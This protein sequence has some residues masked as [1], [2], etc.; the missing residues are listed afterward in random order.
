MI[1]IRCQHCAKLLCRVSRD[2]FGI[3]EIKCRHCKK[4]NAVSLAVI[5]KQAGEKSAILKF[6]SRAPV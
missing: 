6:P 5:L 3:V 4:P 1:D 2:F